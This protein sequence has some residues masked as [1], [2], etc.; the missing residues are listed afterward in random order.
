[1]QISRIKPLGTLGLS[2]LKCCPCYISTQYKAPGPEATRAG[3]QTGQKPTSF[4]VDKVK[5]TLDM[6]RAQKASQNLYIMPNRISCPQESM[7]FCAFDANFMGSMKICVRQM[8]SGESER[9]W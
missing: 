9:N 8:M 6:P 2:T 4:R 3:H 1:M 5:N 7:K